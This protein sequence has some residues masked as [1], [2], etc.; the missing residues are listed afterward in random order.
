MNILIGADPEVF[1]KRH[2]KFVPACGMI[3]GTK[4]KPFPV[5]SGAVQ[6]DGLALE[7][8]INP[9]STLQEFI[10]N[11]ITVKHELRSL[12]PSEYNLSTVPVA[13]NFLNFNT[14]P[15]ES[16]EL[17]CEPDYNAYTP[18]MIPQALRS[19]P[20]ENVRVGAGHIHIGWRDD[21]VD[22][23]DP[24]HFEE[25]KL[26]I[27]ELDIVLGP[28]LALIEGRPGHERREHYGPLGSFRP[29]SYGVEYRTPSN[30]WT[31]N[32]AMM[33][34]VYKTVMEV[35]KRIM[36]HR[37]GLCH[38][39]VNRYDTIIAIDRAFKYGKDVDVKIICDRLINRA[40]KF[41]YV[42]V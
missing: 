22:P 24:V 37:K 17:G 39:R 35:M 31:K 14:L 13:R 23:L 27:K 15:D 5:K 10:R 26:V 38:E 33:T 40:R 7:Y 32:R 12:I 30:I 34:L 11:V 20:D 16:K 21:N 18:G 28:A 36:D 4:E 42:S 1:V 6:V 8:N 29:K 19:K 25:C 2:N 3:K 41:D 9:A